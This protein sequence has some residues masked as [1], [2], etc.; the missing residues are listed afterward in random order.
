M[1]IV[2]CMCISAAIFLSGLCV[3]IWVYKMYSSQNKQIIGTLK[4]VEAKDEEPYMF[5]ELNSDVGFVKSQNT[6][7]LQ[8]SHK[9]VP[10]K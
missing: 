8:V 6:I 2:V 10:Q 7:L 4:I 1:S 9:I 5:L 3:G